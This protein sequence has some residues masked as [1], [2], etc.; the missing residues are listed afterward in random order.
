MEEPVC[1]LGYYQEQLHLLATLTGITIPQY[2]PRVQNFTPEI[3]PLYTLENFRQQF[4]IS[5]DVFEHLL[6]MVTPHVI[7]ADHGGIPQVSLK[8]G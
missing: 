7:H 5:R 4:R 8:S 1:L 2:I 6:Q 3:I